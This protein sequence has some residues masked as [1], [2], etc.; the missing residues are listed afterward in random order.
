VDQPIT[1]E[2][3]QAVATPKH[4]TVNFNFKTNKPDMFKIMLNNVEIDELQKK[5]IHIFE[6]VI[7]STEDDAITAK[8]D[9]D[10]MSNNVV[11]HLGNKE[12]KEVEIKSILISYGNNQINISS[13]KDLDKYFVFNKFIEK[14]STSNTLK[15]K[16]V[17]GQHN[18]AFS[19][20]R[21]LINLLKKE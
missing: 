15:T 12:V 6:N 13:P 19:F 8:F 7:P 14:D 1:Q 21:N 17:N 3:T 4:L 20:K 11:I 5:N 10:N 9:A 2:D 18:P 16:R